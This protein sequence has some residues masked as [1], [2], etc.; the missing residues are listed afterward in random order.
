MSIFCPQRQRESIMTQTWWLLGGFWLTDRVGTRMMNFLSHFI[1][2]KQCTQGESVTRPTITCCF[3]TSTTCSSVFPFPQ[4]SETQHGVAMISSLAVLLPDRK[5]VNFMVSKKN[6]HTLTDR[7]RARVNNDGCLTH[8]RTCRRLM[9]VTIKYASTNKAKTT[10]INNILSVSVHQY[11]NTDFLTC[12]SWFTSS[13]TTKY[14][15]AL[16][17]GSCQVALERPWSDLM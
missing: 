16:I 5:K 1:P 3:W 17:K 9:K 12:C 4:T 7:W 14:F 11:K 8:T 6:R 13:Q 10:W 2:Y 15:T